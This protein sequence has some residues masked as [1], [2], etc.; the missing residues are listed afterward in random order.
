[1]HGV[2]AVVTYGRTAATPCPTSSLLGSQPLYVC[3]CLPEAAL[4]PIKKPTELS[5]RGSLLVHPSA[6]GSESIDG[7]KAVVS[8]PR[9]IP[10]RNINTF[11]PAGA[12]STAFVIIFVPT[13]TLLLV[14]L[15]PL[16]STLV[17][18]LSR[19]KRHG[20]EGVGFSYAVPNIAVLSMS[21]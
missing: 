8:P 21:T 15:L 20:L 17:S 12:L 18:G 3:A 13:S 14:V 10:L 9:Q 5:Q 7:A 11:S 4:I 6:Y 1:M 2:G 16:F 19:G